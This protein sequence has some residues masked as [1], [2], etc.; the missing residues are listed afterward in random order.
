MV[1]LFLV[2]FSISWIFFPFQKASKT[3]PFDLTVKVNSI[4][5]N[6]GLIEFAL[7]KNPAVFTQAGKTHR[8]ARIDAKAPEVKFQFTNLDPVSYAIVVYHD[9]NSNKICDK[10]IFGI[11]TEAY[12]FSNNKRP[13]LSAPTFEEC[14]VKLD[15][16]KTISIKMVY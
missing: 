6:K 2:V 9:V 4:Q 14:S 1:K 15:K 7:Y 13:K 3:N 5:N 11:P 10:N 12:G 8:L 16:D